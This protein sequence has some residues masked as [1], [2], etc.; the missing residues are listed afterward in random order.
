MSMT[1]IAPTPTD[2][3]AYWGKAR[4]C[5][6]QEEFHL[7]VFHS[8]DVAAVGAAYLRRRPELADWLVVQ[9]GFPDREALIAWLGFWL[10]LHD[11][12]KFSRSFQCQRQDIFS[13]LRGAPPDHVGRPDV[14]HDS[15][16]QW[17][18]CDVLRERIQSAGW[19]GDA[20]N[21]VD[22]ALLW[23]AAV[24][25][26]HGQ[27]PVGEGRAGGA[28]KWHFPEHER[29]SAWA[30]VQEMAQRFL[31]DRVRRHVAS[32]D[33]DQFTRCS[34]QLSWWVAGLAVLAD[35]LGSDAR[36]F[37]YQARPGQGLDAYWQASCAVAD[38]TLRQSGV[39]PPVLVPSPGFGELFP[40]I[41]VPSPLQ[42]WASTVP[43]D[44]Q[45]QLHLLE[46]VT[47]AG[48]TE[49][50]VMLTQRLMA[51]GAADGFFIG[52]P[53]MA[54]AN[55][56]YTRIA[57]VYARLFD[58]VASLALAHGRKDLVE[59]FAASVLPPAW[60]EGDPQQ[61][62]DS[63][64][65]RCA[66]WL[67]DHN[68]RALLAPA[69]VGTIDQAL[70]AVLQAKHQSLR[71]LGLFRKVLVVD[72]VHACDAYMQRT[73][74]A[75]LEFHAAAGGSAI[76][77]SA[78]LPQRMKS[79][80][81]K[82]F[83]RGA[84]HAA[85]ALVSARYPLVSSW[86]AQAGHGQVDE[87]PMAT[88]PDV[89]RTVRVRYEHDLAAVLAAIQSA[90]AR[91]HCVG[92][93]RN[94]VSDVLEARDLLS[95]HVAADKLTVFHAR[96]T[97]GDRLSTE[98]EV[99]AALGP[100]STPATRQGRLLIASQVAEQSLDIDVDLLIS[101]L[102]PIDR[103]IQRAGRLRRH[104]RS[105]DGQRLAPGE[106]DQRGEPWL[107]VHGPAW[108][109]MPPADWYKKLLPKAAHVYDD[110]AQLWLTAKALQAGA[111]TMPGDARMLIEG[112]FGGEAEPP[113]GLLASSTQSEGKA[114]GARSLAQLNSVKLALGYRRD[115]V[116]WLS[117]SSAPSRQGEESVD[118]V[119]ARWRD[120]QLQPWCS[121]RPQH[122][123]AYSTV[124]MIRRQIDQEAPQDD[125]Q[126]QA[127]VAAA[128]AGMPGGG[129][130]V[131]LLVLALEG[132]RWV[133]EALAPARG[134]QAAARR[135]WVYDAQGGL[136]AE[137]A[138]EGA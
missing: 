107:W 66:R 69:G 92:W 128:K 108:A 24:T 45:P 9:S 101:D 37:R 22:G 104:A 43:L 122:A 55:A 79:A 60:E 26:H 109:D 57:Q 136:L 65:S 67:A 97:L 82:A 16:G 35:W 68:K 30:F 71:L 111:F 3:Y 10:A 127:A 84:G 51:T 72:E 85:P 4:P 13:Q 115:G 126:R 112:V 48:K 124:R 27:P 99:L 6:D 56:M 33:G 89:H 21:W 76:L 80:L 137:K 17:L 94:T 88:R 110:H 40:A 74:E 77:L 120:G 113:A 8:L 86:P 95:P 34:Q 131:L 36:A 87:C 49:A 59:G 39:L 98:G 96:F 73:L 25:G 93:I 117:D 28:L 121:D 53:T 81:L 38:R 83:A 123:W 32:V 61:L 64:S 50:A 23:A 44:R 119:L 7:L 106:A 138:P 18:F 12:G 1:S 31:T 52:L 41:A 125:P 70:L 20:D 78:T 132:D 103:L 15:L 42:H 19:F 29:A 11:L 46:D 102:A 14:R 5:V 130:W 47:G 58:G 134:A 118:V 133:G 105:A 100:G 114:H 63:A 75:L 54:T 2:F 91:G 116:D 62:D 90:L 135:R 129:K